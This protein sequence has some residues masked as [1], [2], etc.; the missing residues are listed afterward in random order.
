MNNLLIRESGQQ[1]IKAYFPCIPEWCIGWSVQPA[2]EPYTG[3]SDEVLEFSACM[4]V[5]KGDISFESM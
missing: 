1:P 3:A 4:K 2:Q 5:S